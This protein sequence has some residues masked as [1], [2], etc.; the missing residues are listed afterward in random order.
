MKNPVALHNKIE[1]N[2][3]V[4]TFKIPEIYDN[5]WETK[6]VNNEIKVKKMIKW[7]RG[8]N[9]D[10]YSRREKSAVVGFYFK[11]K[12]DMVEFGLVWV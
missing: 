9:I 11:N 3:F 1:Y 7:L 6:F 8:K 12:E 10:Y 2:Y 5:Y 4:E